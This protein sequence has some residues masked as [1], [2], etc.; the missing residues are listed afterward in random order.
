MIFQ[1]ILHRSL[2][3]S[4]LSLTSEGEERMSNEP[5][6]RNKR[7]YRAYSSDVNSPGSGNPVYLRLSMG[8]YVRLATIIQDRKMTDITREN[9][10]ELIAE[11]YSL[12]DI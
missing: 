1:I 9:V 5:E 11:M 8:D 6:G 12:D 4:Y 7:Q 2:T 10:F 3:K